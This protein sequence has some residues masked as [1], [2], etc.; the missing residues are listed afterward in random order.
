MPGFDYVEPFVA[1]DGRIRREAVI[2]EGF[3]GCCL[4][5]GEVFGDEADEST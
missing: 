4:W 2:E 5:G 3:D 1:G